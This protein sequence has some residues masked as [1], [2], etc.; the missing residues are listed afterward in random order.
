MLQCFKRKPTFPL[1]L[2]RALYVLYD[3]PEVSRDTH[4]HS[5]GTL[6][7]PPKFKKAPFSLP[8]VEMMVDFPLRLEMHADIPVASR[9][10]TGICMTLEG[11]PEALPQF[12]SHA[13]PHPLEIR[14]DFLAPIRMSAKNQLTTRRE[15]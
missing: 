13:F 10:E 9:E 8:Q 4:P 12:K 14:R 15:F 2:D 11:N 5:R 6:S 1:K 3:T 7:F